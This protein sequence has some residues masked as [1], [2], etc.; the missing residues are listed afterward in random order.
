[1]VLREKIEIDQDPNHVRP[2]TVSMGAREQDPNADTDG[3][4][5][6]KLKGFIVQGKKTKITAMLE[7]TYKLRN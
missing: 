3:S 4:Q 6:S 5:K 2:V 7:R 1:M